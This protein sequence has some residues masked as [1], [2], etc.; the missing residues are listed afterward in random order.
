MQGCAKPTPHIT[1]IQRNVSG[2][3]YIWCTKQDHQVFISFTR[4]LRKPSK[5]LGEAATI[6]ITVTVVLSVMA[7]AAVALRLYC[8]KL[9]K[10]SLG[11]DDYCVIIAL[12]RGFTLLALCFIR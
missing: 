9:Q 2:S 11:G 4:S 1:G 10:L 3:V 8:R 12:V 6:I 5:M 7:I